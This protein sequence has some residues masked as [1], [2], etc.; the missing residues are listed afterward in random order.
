ME[1]RDPEGDRYRVQR[2]VNGAGRVVAKVV[3]PDAN[4]YDYRAYFHL[5]ADFDKEDYRFIDFESGMRFVE[6]K[7]AERAA[8]A[9]DPRKPEAT[10]SK[11]VETASP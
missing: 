5:E 11:A 10:E 6:A 8:K 2:L 7:L 9:A 1:G 3:A 4:Q